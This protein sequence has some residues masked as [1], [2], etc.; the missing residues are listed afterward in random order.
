MVG[1]PGKS[2]GCNTCRRRKIRCDL[3]KPTCDRCAQS[4]REC[5]GYER[6][7]TFLN[8]NAQG[9]QRRKPLEE[10]K[11]RRSTLAESSSARLSQ[12][13][14]QTALAS[15]YASQ[16][17]RSSPLGQPD[18]VQQYERQIFATFMGVYCP[19][20]V[21]LPPNR[22]TTWFHLI[23]TMEDPGDTLRHA[24]KALAASRVAFVYNDPNM[25]LRAYDAYGKALREL[26]KALWDPNAMYRD[27]TL[28]AARALV[29]FEI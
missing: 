27:E 23:P 6:F 14:Q 22:F 12:A 16:G 24:A 21:P 4:G 3:G 28:A 19:A 25:K 10:A 18:A 5:E 20:T 8:R 7:P 11:P 29:A 9:L 15:A 2:K 1:V 17:G 26:Q 13:Q